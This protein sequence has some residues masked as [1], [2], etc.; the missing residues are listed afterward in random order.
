MNA[1]ADLAARPGTIE[2]AAARGLSLPVQL[3]LAWGAAAIVLTAG[4]WSLIAAGELKGP[5]DMLRMVQVR[6]F[7]AGQ[8]W[9]DVTQQ[10]LNP[11]AGVLM[12]WSRLV[13]LP[14]AG[15]IVLLTPLLGAAAAETAAAVAV[16]LLTLLV[17]M[18]FAAL[19][20]RRL[21]GPKWA[22][23][24]A[25]FIPAMY[26]VSFQVQPMRID[27][28][29]WQFALAAI[30]L[31][32]FL[33]P[34]RPMAGIL[35]GA[36]LALWLHISLEALPYAFAFGLAGAVLVLMDAREAQRLVAMLGGLAMVSGAL[37][38]LTQPL[39]GWNSGWCDA[40]APAHIA[41][42]LGAA[43]MSAALLSPRTRGLSARLGLLAGAGAAAAFIFTASAPQCIASP[44]GTL[45]P[46]V[47]E[48]WYE[49]VREGQPVW[50][51]EPASVLGGLGAMALGAAGYAL[52]LR[53][54]HAP[55]HRRAWV[56]AAIIFAVAIVIALLVRRTLGTASIYALPGLMVLLV[57]LRRRAAS[58]R[59][60]SLRSFA[61]AGAL[62]LVFPMT[63]PLVIHYGGSLLSG[64][65]AKTAPER[66]IAAC[67]EEDML[68]R[69]RM[70]DPALILAPFDLAPRL[71]LK[72]PHSVVAS[73][74]HRNNEAMRDAIRAFMSEPHTAE[75][76]A[77]RRGV[78]YVLTCTSLPEVSHYAAR[79][80]QGLQAVLETSK[81]PPWLQHVH[82]TPEGAGIWKVATP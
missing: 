4:T 40:A 48:I 15:L 41:A 60:E 38:L 77:R 27:H 79:A 8:P 1:A 57:D 64:T 53:S 37:F 33:G 68:A 28:H 71:L 6:D 32:C 39:A 52:A 20:V 24:A 66:K 65:P 43:V 62:V 82:V 2:R 69:L 10:R 72:T 30:A 51:E 16:P 14:L 3:L 46:L 12:H 21:A 25:L 23:L 67:L 54:S 80:P 55:Q 47:R 74:H 45:D 18:I 78:D 76:I 13:D 31:F 22:I 29:G 61:R 26:D 34:R 81:A 11:P 73:A 44:F 5:D 63:L 58:L 70:L 9:E 35:A 19:I 59:S 56:A 50:R 17:I 42:F 75:A 36:A 7:L 49:A